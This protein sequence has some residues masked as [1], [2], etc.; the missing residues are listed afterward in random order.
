[1]NTMKTDKQIQ[2]DVMAELNWEPSVDATHI[3][4]AVEGGIVT[5]SGHV[6]NYAEKWAAEKAALRVQGVRAVAEEIDVKLPGSSKRTDVDIA[7]AAANALTWNAWL[8][9]SAI[10]VKVEDGT[11]TLSGE[12][13]WEY[14]RRRAYDAVRYLT[15]V[16]SVVNLMTV[17]PQ[18]SA[19]GIKD[20]IEAAF[21]RTAEQDA[22]KVNVVVEGGKVMLKGDVRSYA[23]KRAA[24]RAAWS[25]P[26]VTSVK[27]NIDVRPYAYA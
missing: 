22:E 4:V 9:A 23:E 26:G 5:L 11:V 19:A 16:K 10:H 7:R 1:M 25:A 18:L 21:E 3:G 13:P 20:K 27:N 17:K 24:E 14:Q 8:P 6:P 12:V 2:Q 15:G